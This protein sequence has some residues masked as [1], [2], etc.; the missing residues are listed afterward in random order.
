MA[1]FI[2]PQQE[3]AVNCME[4]LQRNPWVWMECKVYC[5]HL[6]LLPIKLLIDYCRSLNQ[7]V[8]NNQ[9]IVVE[10]VA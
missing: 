9:V 10:P 3:I 5:R 8:C 6:M 1:I 2:I 4:K 7:H